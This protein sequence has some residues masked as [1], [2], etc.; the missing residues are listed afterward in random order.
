[1]CKNHRHAPYVDV[2]YIQHTQGLPDAQWGKFAFNP[3]VI[4]HVD[5][6]LTPRVHHHTSPSVLPARRICCASSWLLRNY[7]PSMVLQVL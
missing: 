5:M 7:G 4:S 2:D 6:A 3:Q 1:M